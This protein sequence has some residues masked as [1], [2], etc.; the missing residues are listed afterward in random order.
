MELNQLRESLDEA[1]QKQ[2]FTEAADIKQKVTELEL[3]KESLIAELEEM[4]TV[5]EVRQEKVSSPFPILPHSLPLL[6][7]LPSPFPF[8]NFPPS[9]H[10]DLP[11]PVSPFLCPI[12][13]VE[14]GPSINYVTSKL[15]IFTPPPS[16]HLT[17]SVKVLIDINKRKLQ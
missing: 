17:L 1:I 4:S 9:T 14:W 10:S 12:F 8:P 5:Q 3:Q 6:P 7:L 13:S 16:P 11:S 2:D 15:A